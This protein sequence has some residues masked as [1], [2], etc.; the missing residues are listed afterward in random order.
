MTYLLDTD[1]CIFW[2]RGHSV[3]REHINSVGPQE[4]ALS[5]ITL[6]ELRYGAAVSA[7]P[8]N[9]H[10]A[11]ENLVRFLPIINLDTEIVRVYGETKGQL[12]KE[13]ALIEDFDLLIA[14]TSVAHGLT[15]VTNNTAHF[16]R[17]PVLHLAN[18]VQSI[19]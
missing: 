3:V 7:R 5:I 14:A 8:Q 11:I 1:T 6:A 2:L 9:N 17:I 10:E 12:R 4:M 13:G 16:S 18:W 19:D 15:L